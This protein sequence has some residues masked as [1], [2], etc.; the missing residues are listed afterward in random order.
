MVVIKSAKANRYPFMPTGHW[1]KQGLDD[2][3][4]QALNAYLDE[5]NLHP[6][7]TI[8]RAHSYYAETTIG[9]MAPTS[10]VVFMG[11]CGVSI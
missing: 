7:V 1:M 9:Y 10:K 5:N 6:T 2:R 8:H 11:S 3:A 4:Q